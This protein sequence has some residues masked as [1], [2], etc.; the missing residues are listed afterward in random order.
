MARHIELGIEGENL[1]KIYLEQNGFK[2][3]ES[4]Y[5][6][7]QGE[8]D[9]VAIKNS[10]LVFVEVKLRVNPKFYLSELI[11]FSKQNKIIQAA[12]HYIST[13][14]QNLGKENLI[15]RF[16]VALVES[17]DH[18]ITYIENAFTKNY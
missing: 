7:K 13:K 1:V 17:S 2:I 8:V 5:K 11:T 4:N 16:D 9:I 10:V 18:N 6:T 15:Y 3:L 14:A 12:L